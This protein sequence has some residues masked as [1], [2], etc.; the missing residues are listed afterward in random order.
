MNVPLFRICWDEADIKA[1]ENV[2]KKG[3]SWS[4]GPEI[5]EFEKAI[6][7]YLGTKYCV[8]FN[9]GTSALH[10][11]L[12]AHDICCGE[13]IVPSFTFI[14]TANAALFVG[15]KP[16]FADIEELTFGMD[17]KDVEKK[18][19]KDTKAIIPVHYGGCPC[20][21]EEMKK[22]AD[23]NNIILIE[24]AAE[25]MG[26][27]KGKKMVGSF[28]DSSVLSFC[29]NK[30]ITTGEGG[31]V[32]TNNSDIYKRLKL[33]G[34]HGREDGNYFSSGTRL[35]YISLGY[36]F[37]IPSMIAALGISQLS[38]IDNIIKMREAA[39]SHYRKSL[40]G[41]DEIEIPAVPAGS[42]NAYQ[43]FT[44]V[45]KGD[46]RDELAAYLDKDGIAS[47]VYFDPIHLSKFYREKFGYQ[48]GELPLTES[49]SK[50]ILS[51]PI[52]PGITNEEIKYVADS[53][54]DFFSRR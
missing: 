14:A 33:I 1:V 47:K 36:N 7:K 43:L 38:K 21:I 52:Y 25:A 54:R 24:D 9:S 3:M 50:H 27:E 48:G 32:V 11:A 46:S 37:R 16:V 18:I 34:S 35:D 17:P 2:M 31:A 26:S 19:T 12:L 45:V 29:Q 28:G 13:V 20:Q 51:L 8:T 4:C 49:I 30:I 10:A 23:E 5:E 15:A 41:I 39:V 22:I 53:I 6:A 40:S 42:R 44:I